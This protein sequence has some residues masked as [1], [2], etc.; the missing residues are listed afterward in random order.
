MAGNCKLRLPLP[1]QI[2]EQPDYGNQSR[3]RYKCN[4]FNSNDIAFV[5]ENG[6][7]DFVTKYHQYVKKKL[8]SSARDR[9]VIEALE[10]LEDGVLDKE[11]RDA[12]VKLLSERLAAKVE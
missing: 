6:L 8:G 5:P 9:A 2:L 4:F 12:N 11:K 1:I 3:P 7:F 10:S